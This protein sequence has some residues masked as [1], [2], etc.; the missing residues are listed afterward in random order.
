M[1]ITYNKCSTDEW[2][3]KMQYIYTTEY[4]SAIK[5]EW[6]LAQKTSSQIENGLLTAD[7]WGSR[8][9]GEGNQKA[10]TSNYKTGHGNTMFSTVAVVNNTVFC[11]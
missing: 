8:P 4:Y 11:I 7:R 2:I 3:K 5:K 1:K 9:M 10:Q 6:N